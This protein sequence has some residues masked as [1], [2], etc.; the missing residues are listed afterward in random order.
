MIWTPDWGKERGTGQKHLAE[1]TVMKEM[2]LSRGEAQAKTQEREGY[3]CG[4]MSQ[5]GGRWTKRIT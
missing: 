1:L 5:L 3:D 2:G 4:F